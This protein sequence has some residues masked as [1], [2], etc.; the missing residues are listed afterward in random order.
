[1]YIAYSINFAALQIATNNVNCSAPSIFPHS[2]AVVGSGEGSAGIAVTGA[3]AQ[4]TVAPLFASTSRNVGSFTSISTFANFGSNNVAN[5]PQSDTPIAL[6]LYGG[7]GGGVMISNA[8][9]VSQVSGPFET[10]TLSIPAVSLSF[11]FGGGI[12]ELQPTAGPGWGVS[13]TYST[14]N[15]VVK[16][17][18]QPCRQG[19]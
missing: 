3:S 15:T 10:Y 5:V 6:G 11:S 1:M 17:N 14:S 16:S 7:V 4:Q 19:G 2:V 18:N 12:W 8:T 13:H 9:N